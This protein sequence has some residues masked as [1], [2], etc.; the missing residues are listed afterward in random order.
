MVSENTST[1]R[2]NTEA[3]LEAS[4]EVGLETSI[5]E[6]KY[7]VMSHHQNA[8]Q[9]HSLLTANKSF[10]N[11]PKFR[12]LETIVTNQNCI[13]QEIKIK[14][15]EVNG[16][17]HFVQIFLSSHLLSKNFQIKMYITIIVTVLHGHETW[18]LI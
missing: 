9:S 16:C 5:E 17:Y 4:R 12:Y 13:H 14:L 3:L 15:N 1:L 2:R 11:V 6:T 7:M 10:E 8:G 18:S